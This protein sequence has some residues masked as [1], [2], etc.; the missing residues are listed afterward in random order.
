[1]IPLIESKSD[2]IR[3]LCHR[4]GVKRLEVFGSATDGSFDPAHSDLDFLVEFR[5]LQEMNAFHQFFGLQIA[6]AELFARKVD[7][8]DSTAMRNPYFIDSVNQSRTLLYAV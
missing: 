2:Q 7:L 3:S 4:F 6:L 5:P 1:M 8:V